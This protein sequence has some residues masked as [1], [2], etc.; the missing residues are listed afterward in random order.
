MSGNAYT[1]VRDAMTTSPYTI[2]GLA[3][4]AEA[5]ELMRRHQVSSL[6]VDRRHEGDEYGLLAVHDIAA[7][8]VQGDRPP[9]RLSVYEVMT[10]PV[11]T[12]DADMDIKYAIRL[13]S[14]FGLSRT[15]ATEKG[16]LAGIVTLR[17]MVLRYFEAKSEKG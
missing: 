17:D 11:I 10:K 15:L 14:R 16:K 7:K 3:N 2:D 13:I 1:K 8:V 12:V 9:E 6:V 4:V 5:V